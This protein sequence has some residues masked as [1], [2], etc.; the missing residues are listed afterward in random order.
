MNHF[1]LPAPVLAE[2]YHIGDACKW[3][4]RMTDG[5][6]RVAPKKLT[7]IGLRRNGELAAGNGLLL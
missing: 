1:P 3:L 4:N 7:P 2:P 5:E 6:A